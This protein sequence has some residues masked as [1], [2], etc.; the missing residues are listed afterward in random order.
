M[1]RYPSLHPTVAC[2][3]FWTGTRRRCGPKRWGAS[4]QGSE[5][6][7]S[8]AFLV[9]PTGDEDCSWTIETNGFMEGPVPPFCRYI[10]TSSV[11]RERERP[12]EWKACSAQTDMT[13]SPC[14]GL[15]DD[16]VWRKTCRPNQKDRPII[17]KM[18]NIGIIITLLIDFDL[19]CK[20]HLHLAL[21]DDLINM[22]L[23]PVDLWQLGMF[24]VICFVLY[25]KHK[26]SLSS[27]LSARKEV[28][29]IHS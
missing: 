8:P 26:D 11:G 28:W 6:W 22:L 4:H 16:L 14:L 21:M 23:G 19:E 17:S 3:K 29:L 1:L 15:T 2:E 24:S 18:E 12:Q 7:Y 20:C 25:W 9:Q 13:P 10:M 5:H 27:V